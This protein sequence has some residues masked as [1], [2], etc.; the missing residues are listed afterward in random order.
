[1]DS[2][3]IKFQVCNVV[4]STS[5]HFSV[6]LASVLEHGGLNVRGMYLFVRIFKQCPLMDVHAQCNS[7]TGKIEKTS[8]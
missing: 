1:M 4:A 6:G 2:V 5:A 7:V 8:G 3:S